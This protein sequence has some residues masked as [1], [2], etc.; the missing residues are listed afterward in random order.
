LFAQPSVSSQARPSPLKPSVQ[1][2]VCWSGPMWLHVALA[3]QVL[4]SGLA[5]GMISAQVPAAARSATAAAFEG[6]G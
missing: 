4:V 2:Q 3:E 6:C 1:L 5:H